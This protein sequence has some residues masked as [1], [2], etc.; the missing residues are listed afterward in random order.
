MLNIVLRLVAMLLKRSIS[1]YLQ[2]GRSHFHCKGLT[3][4]LIFF[5]KGGHFFRENLHYATNAVT[6]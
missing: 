3:A 6:D 4:T 5:L 1:N 2:T